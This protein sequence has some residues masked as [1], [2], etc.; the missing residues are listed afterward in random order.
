[1]ASMASC[2][3]QLEFSSSSDRF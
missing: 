3:R 2:F 1:M